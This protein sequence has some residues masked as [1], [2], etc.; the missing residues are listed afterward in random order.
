MSPVRMATHA[1]HMTTTTA[2][3]KVAA[4][5]AFVLALAGLAAGTTAAPSA[6]ATPGQVH[7]LPPLDPAALDASIAGLPNRDVTSAQVQVSGPDGRWRGASGVTDVKHARDVRP[8]ARF[9]IGSATKMF[10][11]A[12]VLQLVSEH[13]LSLGTRVQAVLPGLL[14]GRFPPITVGE[15]LDH[16]SGL[17][18]STED[19]GHDDPAWV[20]RH[21]L[22]YFSPRQVVRSAVEHRM[23]FEPGTHQQYNGV[24]YFLAGLVVERITHDTFIHQL[25]IRILHPLGLHHTSLPRP[26]RVRIVGRH[27]HGYVRVGHR[28]ADVT[29]QSAYS[30]AEGGMVST[31]QDLS[32]FLS[33][34]LRGRVLA[35]PELA[36]MMQVPDVPYVGTTGGC[37]AGPDAG[38]ACF[39]MG[40]QRTRL[41]GGLVLWGKSGGTAGYA[42]LVVAPRDAARVL[43]VGLTPTGNRDGTEGEYLLRIAAA[44]FGIR[45]A[46]P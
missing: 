1:R 28:L 20:V 34:L 8:G 15:L 31:T 4:L 39:S 46:A 27:V 38:K 14:P 18:A 35:R 42:T 41:P 21:R 16:T 23:Q 36:R 24:N 5:L 32:R 10:T 9:R 19:A 43:A 37:A 45:P 30:W 29:E 17:P 12:I 22:D 2:F 25:R 11:A 7:R 26:A 33:A 3:S 40:L 13:R 44:A 6:R